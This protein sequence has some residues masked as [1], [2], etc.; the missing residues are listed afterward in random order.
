LKAIPEAPP[1]SDADR[2]ARGLAPRGRDDL[3]IE[4]PDLPAPAVRA[5]SAGEAVTPPG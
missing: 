4:P 3:P 5:D 1:G 2:V